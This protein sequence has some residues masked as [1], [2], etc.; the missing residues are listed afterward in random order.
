ME[1]KLDGIRPTVTST[2]KSKKI[3]VGNVTASVDFGGESPSVSISIDGQQSPI[4]QDLPNRGYVLDG[5]GIAHYTRYNRNTLYVGLG[6]KAAPMNLS[7]RRFEL[8]A[9]DSFGY[10]VYRT[11]PLY[12]N[13]PFLI[14]ATPDGCVATFSTSQ[15]RGQYSIGSEMDGMV[16]GHCPHP[17]L[18]PDANGLPVGVL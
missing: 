3:Q 9:T 6:E 11:D 7:G 4:L 16:S 10:D 17:P 1:T 8:S 2:S 15:G 5:S 12:K 13:I 14:N 18:L